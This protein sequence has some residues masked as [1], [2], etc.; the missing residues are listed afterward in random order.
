MI[1]E[2]SMP[3]PTPAQGLQ[4]CRP[5]QQFWADLSDISKNPNI[6]TRATGLKNF[7]FNGLPGFEPVFQINHYGGANG[8]GRGLVRTNQFLHTDV[9]GTGF[10][11]DWK[12]REF[13]LKTLCTGTACTPASVKVTPLSRFFA[14]I[15][16]PQTISFQNFF[17][18][19]VSGLAVADVNRFN[20]TP[21]DTFNNSE[22][23]SQADN[24][25]GTFNAA[26][27]FASRI[28]GA[29]PAGS[30]LTPS[31]IVA[32][33]E[34]LSCAGCHEQSLG[35]SIGA[36]LRFPPTVGSQSFVMV[37]ETV[38]VGPDGNRFIVNPSLTETFLPFRE[39]VVRNFLN[40]PPPPSTVCAAVQQDQTT[41]LSCAPGQVMKTVS[42]A[43]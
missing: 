15:N 18:G 2:G 13:K 31:D 17:I 7:Y 21:P 37:N 6:T 9:N 16:D 10:S 19:A 24:F 26:G 41:T 20:Y 5:I 32:R 12:L 36:G 35:A 4:G 42:F 23:D 22:S 33:A 1:F 11:E 39:S 40:A 38:E 28:A 25:L 34:A 43:R 8:T 30:G 27:P 3:N 29:I 14:D